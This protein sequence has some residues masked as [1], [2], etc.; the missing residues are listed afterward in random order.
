MFVVVVVVVVVVVD[1]AVVAVVAVVVVVVVCLSVI[2][3]YIYI[4]ICVVLLCFR[5]SGLMMG[6]GL[7]A[8]SCMLPRGGYC[9]KY[10]VQGHQ[11]EETTMQLV[12]N[13]KFIE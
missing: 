11:F 5:S 7:A 12:L 1:V 6:T 4:Y 3:I 9:L 13:H 10:T 2:Y 8:S